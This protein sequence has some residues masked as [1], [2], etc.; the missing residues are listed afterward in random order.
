[1]IVPTK[2]IN[3]LGVN[4]DDQLSF[5]E[6]NS[7]ISHACRFFCTTP[8]GSDLTSQLMLMLY[9]KWMLEMW[10]LLSCLL[11]KGMMVKEASLIQPGSEHLP[12]P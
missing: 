1:M 2:S 12:S 6:N 3:N 10:Q 11:T 5:K 8:V 9:L 7:T 4:T